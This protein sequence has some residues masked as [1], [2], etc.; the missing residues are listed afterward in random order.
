MV[1][2]TRSITDHVFI[3]HIS[4]IT[5]AHFLADVV[6]A[7]GHSSSILGLLPPLPQREARSARSFHRQLTRLVR[8][9]R[10]ITDLP[11]PP[12]VLVAID[13]QVFLRGVLL[14]PPSVFIFF[15]FLIFP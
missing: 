4:S 1:R 3:P 12:E 7:S 14:V 11:P 10:D 2:S 9:T 5:L 6:Q 8:S 13:E 15:L